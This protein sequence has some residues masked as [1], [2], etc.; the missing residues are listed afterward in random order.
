VSPTAGLPQRRRYS[1]G[2]CRFSRVIASVQHLEV[3]IPIAASERVDCV[4]RCDVQ[5]TVT[6]APL[7]LFMA[8]MYLRCCDCHINFK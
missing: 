2:A 7:P 8:V 6:E 3:R 4:H 1:D 5:V